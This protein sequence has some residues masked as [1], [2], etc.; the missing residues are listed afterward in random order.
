MKGCPSIYRLCEVSLCGEVSLSREVS[1]SG[2][3]RTWARYRWEIVHYIFGILG[4]LQMR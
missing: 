2:Y 3:N 1:N 4:E